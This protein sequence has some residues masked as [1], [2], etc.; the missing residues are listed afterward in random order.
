MSE[1]KGQRHTIYVV[2]KTFKQDKDK[3]D[4]VRIVKGD[5]HTYGKRIALI[6]FQD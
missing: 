5:T 6:A 1:I 4:S 2:V 3:I